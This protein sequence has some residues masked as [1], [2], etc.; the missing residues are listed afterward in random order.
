MLRSVFYRV[1][2]VLFVLG[3]SLWTLWPTFRYYSLTA[4]EKLNL[5]SEYVSNLKKRALNLGLD[6]QGGMYMVLEV[7]KSKLSQEEAKGAEERALEI[8]RNRID[9]WGVSE[10]VIQKTE[11]GRIILQLPGV[12][13]RER[14]EELIG[15]TA[16]LEFKLVAD[17]KT[18]EQTIKNIDDVLQKTWKGDTTKTYLTDILVSFRGGIGISSS[19][20]HIFKEI[21][22]L[23]EVQ[24]VIPP[25]Y[26][27]LFG[28][29]EDTPEGKIKPVY[30]VKKEPELTGATLKTARHTIYQGQ[31]PAYAGKPI[32]EIHFDKKGAT[33]FAFVTGAN[34]GK[35]LAIVLDSVVQSAPVIEERIPTGD[36][37]IRGN[38]T[39]DE[40][41]ELAIILRAGALPAPIKIV[42]ERTV[43]ATLGKD[44][45]EKGMKAFVVGLIIVVMFMV[46]YYKLAGLIA[47]LALIL[48]AIF[49]LAVMVALRATLTLPGIAGLIL[50]VGMAVDANVLIFE[51]IREELRAGK[52]PKS[53][54]DAGFAK[55][56]ITIFDANLTTLIAALVLLRF[57]VGP[58]KGF[59]TVLSIGILSNFFTAIFVSKIIFDYLVNVKRV[60]KLS[61]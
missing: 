57:G 47:D 15:K 34:I 44:S 29:A 59:G 61:I 10:P 31:D 17:Q 32:V 43:G 16:L 58:I 27:F 24:A 19:K 36:A 1:L 30:L 49:I 11:E 14:A 38:F 28:K 2:V 22:N 4:E 20:V 39:I 6:L 55:A 3:I 26:E 18:L 25:G 40:A 37:I 60:E 12:L 41:K 13:E 42:E 21:I 23:P 46:I 9:Q 45:I 51:R 5:S 35:Q 7:D 8:I 53:A 50:T 56:T 33:K 54:V 52:S 48:N